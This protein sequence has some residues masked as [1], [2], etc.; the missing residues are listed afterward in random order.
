MLFIVLILVLAALG[1]V[2]T[3][4][5]TADSLWAWISI[6]VSLLAGLVLVVDWL[7]RRSARPDA[8]QAGAPPETAESSESAE[9]TENLESTGTSTSD[10]S[11]GAEPEDADRAGDTDGAQD[12]QGTQDTQDTGDTEA[13][14]D[15]GPAADSEAAAPAADTASTE[16]S[17]EAAPTALLPSSGELGGARDEPGEEDTDASDVLVVSSLDVEVLVV[18]EHPRYHLQDCSWL[19]DRATIPIAVA[20]ARELGFTP[21]ARCAP[22]ATLAAR[23]RE[24]RKSRK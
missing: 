19:A 15:T 8:E 4:L 21:C 9:N 13:A 7:R 3:A 16:R 23:H 24:K 5:V 6:G 12:T 11:A 1:L 18:D 10:T 22:D 17:G 20:E 2:V 14:E